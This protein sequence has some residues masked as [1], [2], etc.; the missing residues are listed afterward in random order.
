VQSRWRELLGG[1]ALVLNR[2]EAVARGWFGEVSA[3]VLPR[4]GDVVAA[5]R[6]DWG[7]FSNVDFPYETRLI[8]LH[9]SLTP[10]EMRIPMLVA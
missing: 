4:L 7:L 5:A 6:D 8:G 10:V 3:A 9:G 1:G 2:D